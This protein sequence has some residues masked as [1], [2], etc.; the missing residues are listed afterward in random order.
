[1]VETTMVE[2]ELIH[3]KARDKVNYAWHKVII[4]IVFIDALT[5]M[6]TWGF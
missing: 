4:Y 3:I 6:S 5:F 2:K 1:M